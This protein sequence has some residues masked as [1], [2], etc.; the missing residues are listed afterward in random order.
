MRE[1]RFVEITAR[2]SRRFWLSIG[3]RLC[4][5]HVQAD[6]TCQASN[7]IINALAI[8]FWWDRGFELTSPAWGS[9]RPK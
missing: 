8:V 7:S 3:F 4:A 5:Q 9:F 1:A 2:I 6:S